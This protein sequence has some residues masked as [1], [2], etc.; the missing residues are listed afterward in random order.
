MAKKKNCKKKMGTKD[1]DYS[2]FK[3]WGKGKI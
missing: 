3:G 2:G 1:F